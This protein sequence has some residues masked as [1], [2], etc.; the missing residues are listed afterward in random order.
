MNSQQPRP[1]KYHPDVPPPPVPQQNWQ[2][3]QLLQEKDRKISEMSKTIQEYQKS[4]QEQ[5]DNLDRY[6]EKH[7]ELENKLKFR[8]EQIKNL[9]SKFNNI[10][11]DTERKDKELSVQ[12]KKACDSEQEIMI[13]RKENQEIKDMISKRKEKNVELVKENQVLMKEIAGLNVENQKKYESLLK[14][15]AEVTSLKEDV[16]NHET[17]IPESDST[18]H[19][20]SKLKCDFCSEKFAKL[21]DLKNHIVTNHEAKNKMEV[22]SQRNAIMSKVL[23]LKNAEDL[24]TSVH[25][26]KGI[27]HISHKRYDFVPKL[28][29]I[30]L[31]KF[32][33]I[34]LETN[35]EN[36]ETEVNHCDM[37]FFNDYAYKSD[38]QK[39][40]VGGNHYF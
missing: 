11:E 38:R 20:E 28:S 8:E 36:G 22:L 29:N 26:C 27:C 9:N 25:K 13:L 3:I 37:T 6:E 1:F 12:K 16:A 18:K 15:T 33:S 35:I 10:L 14:L 17:M 24:T 39:T 19:V 40:Q 4:V 30:W 7:E 2:W 31:E 32:N 34:N 21:K 5:D 23:K